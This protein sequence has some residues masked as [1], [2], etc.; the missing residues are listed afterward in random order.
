MGEATRF[1]IMF[2]MGLQRG[3]YWVRGKKRFGSAIEHLKEE[4][5]YKTGTLLHENN[6]QSSEEPPPFPHNASNISRG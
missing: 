3:V 1:M 5:I 2:A 6:I 4:C